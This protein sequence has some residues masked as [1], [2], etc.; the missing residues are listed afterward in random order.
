M[1]IDVEK[2]RHTSLHLRTAVIFVMNS[3]CSG[4][5][6]VHCAQASELSKNIKGEENWSNMVFHECILF[7][8]SSIM[9]A[10]NS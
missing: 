6:I 4:Y 9:V 1:K 5:L 2:N 7:H 8:K 3:L 10:F